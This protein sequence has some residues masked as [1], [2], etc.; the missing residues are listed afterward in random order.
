MNFDFQGIAPLRDETREKLQLYYDLCADR[1]HDIHA[2]S[3]VEQRCVES[4]LIYAAGG[5]SIPAA[6]GTSPDPTEQV[7]IWANHPEVPVQ[8]VRDYVHLLTRAQ[9]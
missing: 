6:G 8:R 7:A 3:N 1:G 2:R 5:P 4:A 9:Q